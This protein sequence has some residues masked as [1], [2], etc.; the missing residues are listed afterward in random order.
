VGRRSIFVA[1]ALLAP[2]IAAA[3]VNDLVLSR[4]AVQTDDG[5]G[6]I[7]FV[8]QNADLR[9]LSSQLGVVLAPHMLTPAD[10]LGFGGFQFTVDYA[11]TTIDP[12]AAYWRA[13]EGSPD[14][15]GSGGVA[16]G[17]AALNTVGFFV[18]KGM[19]FPVPAFEFGG[20][21]VHLVDSNIWTGQLYAKLALHEGYHQL[22]IPSLSVRGA[23]SRMMTQ[24]ELDLTVASIDVLVSK[25]FGIG[26]TW[27]FDP[28]VGFDLLLIIPRSEVIDPTPQVD[29]LE[30]GN[31]ADSQKSFVFKNQANIY[32][33]RLVVGAKLQYYILQ[34]TI[35]A[36]IAAAGTSVDDRVGTNDACMLQSLT[37]NCD[38]KDTA[39]SQR[40]LSVSLGLDF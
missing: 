9:A 22:P 8:P 29:S 24:R 14:P 32:R 6:G 25:H 21:A 37:T 16:H 11:T 31:E 7:K 34:L 39:A 17:P 40:T 13:R 38:A 19:W 35:E 4:L 36:D 5:A 20:G 18:R 1:V 12:N 26:G 33:N 15:A 2:G 3:D 30:V 28:Y 10:T 27:R 23:V